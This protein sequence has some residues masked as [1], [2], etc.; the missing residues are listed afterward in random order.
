[1]KWVLNI[2]DAN[3]MAKKY[4]R[5]YINYLYLGF[6]TWAKK[7]TLSI[8]EHH[9]LFL[10]LRLLTYK[11]SIQRVPGL[12]QITYTKPENDSVKEQSV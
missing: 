2:S 8:L 6:V 7:S 4:S 10:F 5:L 1:M 3:T 9:L 11:V 12:I